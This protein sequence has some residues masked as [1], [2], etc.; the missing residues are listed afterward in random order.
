MSGN[1]AGAAVELIHSRNI[2]LEL[3]PDPLEIRRPLRNSPEV[4][5]TVFARDIVLSDGRQI[6]LIQGD[7]LSEG[8]SRCCQGLS[9]SRGP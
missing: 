9:L 7:G 8:L 3:T 6:T 5:L 4:L 1:D 2:F